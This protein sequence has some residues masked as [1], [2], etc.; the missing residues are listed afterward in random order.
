MFASLVKKVQKYPSQLSQME[1][2][3]QGEHQSIVEAGYQRQVVVQEPSWKVAHCYVRDHQ[4]FIQSMLADAYLRKVESIADIRERDWNDIK[5]PLARLDND[6]Y[7]TKKNCLYC[8]L[9]DC[10]VEVKYQ[11]LQHCIDQA[12]KCAVLN[13]TLFD[14]E[15]QVKVYELYLRYCSVDVVIKPAKQ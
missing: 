5:L 1:I 12:A 15:W 10:C 8:Q 13:G 9:A 6:V 4:H 11:E 2:R 7:I 3:L 14:D